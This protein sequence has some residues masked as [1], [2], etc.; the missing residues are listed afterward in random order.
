VKFWLDWDWPGAE[1]AFQKSIAL[2]PN[3]A[4]PHRMLG[5]MYAHM[6]RYAEGRPAMQRVRELEPMVAVYHALSSQVAFMGRDFAAA[7][8]FKQAIV[9]DPEFWVGHLQLGQTCEQLGE[10][11]E[12]LH[13]LNTAAP[14]RT[15]TVNR[16]RCAATFSPN[17]AASTKLAKL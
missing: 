15:A 16:C 5:I 17:L 12:A 3:Y 9:I 7:K 4:L 1:I 8:Q 6:G 10:H 11:D 2:D 13:A 14:S